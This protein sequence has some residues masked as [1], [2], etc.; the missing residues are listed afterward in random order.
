MT[1]D[2]RKE[3]GVLSARSR[4]EAFAL[5]AARRLQPVLIREEEGGTPAGVPARADAASASTAAPRSL[6]L[7]SA[8]QLLFIRELVELLEAGLQ[9]EQALGVM[10]NREERSPV[11]PV[12][13]AL[14]VRIREGASFSKAISEA[15]AGFSPLFVGVCAA[16]EASGA[17][18]QILKSQGEFMAFVKELEGKLVS[19]LVYPSVVLLAGVGL[20]IVFMTFLLPQL[21]T[22]LGKTGQKLPL[23]T[24]ML[25]GASDWF[26]QWWWTLLI[27]A[28]VIFVSHRAWV[29]TPAGRRAWDAFLLK[30]PLLGDML[31]KR[32]LAQFLQTLA[33]LVTNGVVL[34]NA[35]ALVRGTF[36]N[37][38]IDAA[39]DKVSAD[40]AEGISLS[41][42]MKKQTVFPPALIDIVRIGEQTG[43]IGTALGRGAQKYDREFTV[44]MGRFST[45]I[46][47]LSILIVALFVG[48]VAYAMITGILTTVSGLRMR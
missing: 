3:E 38:T 43:D 27:A 19:A 42:S 8:Q 5:L 33:T 12:A 29:K 17:L 25:V 41:R 2:G 30:V 11:K 31:L 32:F 4:S 18:P 7:G 37:T 1:S 21:T 34:L 22:L 9:L 48:L 24:R 14:R 40:V 46:Q 45:L 15:R 36:G 6:R 26:G 39:I 47:P 13:G 23:V 35:L 16:G 44:A 28:V 20:L 10:E